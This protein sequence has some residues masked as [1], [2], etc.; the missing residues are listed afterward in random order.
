MPDPTAAPRRNSEVDRRARLHA[1][2]GDPVRLVIV[3]DL[4]V[5]D[6]SPGEMSASLGVP[7]NLVA[8]H[9][10]VLEQVGLIERY[11]SSGDRRRR[12]VRLVGEPPPAPSP[13]PVPSA[14]RVVFVCTHNSARSP[15]ASALWNSMVGG[16]AESAGTHPVDRFHPGAVAAA[17]RAGLSLAGARPRSLDGLELAGSQVVTVCDRAH[18]ELGGGIGWWHWSTP[19]PLEDAGDGEPF[20]RALDRLRR[21]IEAVTG[22]SGR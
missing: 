22:G 19:D 9:L 2:L 20:D 7:S 18:E 12:Y 3:D 6:R 14:R 10:E 5:S 17:A 15:L 16:G 4:S 13:P 21:R 11:V 1:A 8:H